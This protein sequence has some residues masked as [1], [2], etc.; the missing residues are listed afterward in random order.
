MIRLLLEH[1]ANHF[2]PLPNKVISASLAHL[3]AVTVSSDLLRL[4]LLTRLPQRR[5]PLH[6]AARD[7][8]MLGIARLLIEHDESAGH[9]YCRDGDDLTPLYLACRH[10]N[11][12]VSVRAPA[13]ADHHDGRVHRCLC[14]TLRRGQQMVDLLL[15]HCKLSERMILGLPNPLAKAAGSGRMAIVKRLLR[16]TEGAGKEAALMEAA[17]AG[18]TE[19]SGNI[20]LIDESRSSTRYRQDWMT[21]WSPVNACYVP[22]WLVVSGGEAAAG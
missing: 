9:V 6:V 8:D 11:E 5:L 18:H 1:G 22:A 3:F 19:V 15:S 7:A 14:H 2:D 16:A 17:K 12:A 21:G 20:G 13:A 4:L 10:G